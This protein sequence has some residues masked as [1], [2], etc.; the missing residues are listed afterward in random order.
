MVLFALGTFVIMA[1]EWHGALSNLS[2]ADK[3]HNGWFQSVTLRTA[4]FNTIDIAAVASPTFLIMLC[5]MLIGG[6]PGRLCL[7]FPCRSTL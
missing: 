2:V 7:V 3:L 1:F 5:F 4:G 6:S